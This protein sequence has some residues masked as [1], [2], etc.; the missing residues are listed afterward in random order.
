MGKA[1]F[2]VQSNLHAQGLARIL[3]DYCEQA[4]WRWGG[5]TDLQ[6]EP[7][8]TGSEFAPVKSYYYAP[9]EDR[10]LLSRSKSKF[11][12][13][14]GAVHVAGNIAYLHGP[15]HEG[16]LE[17][18]ND[19][20]LTLTGGHDNVI[21][22][23]ED[24]EIDNNYTPE[25][26]NN[27][28]HSL[29]H[30]EPDHREPN[31]SFRCPNC[32]ELF[33]SY[34]LYLQHRSDEN[35]QS[36]GDTWVDDGKFPELNMDA[37]FPPNTS[38]PL[39]FYEGAAAPQ[40]K[41]VLPAPIPF[42]YDI[43]EDNVIIGQPGQRTSDIPGKFTPGGI[44]EGT[45]EPGGKVMVRS[46]T[47]MPF[48]VR[49]ML[50]LWYYQHPELE[51][52]N[53]EMMDDE[54]KSTKLAAGHDIGGY[55]TSLVGADPTAFRASRALMQRGGNV[56]VVGGAVRDALLGKEPKDIDLMVTG[57]EPDKVH[58]ILTDLPGR[59]DLTGKDFG[60]FRYNQDG[61][62]VEIALP[63][64]E[65]SMGT[66][67]KD[68]DVQADH[69]MT[70]E[71]DLFR[72]DFT[73]NAMAVDVANGQLIDPFHGLDDLK[74]NRL[75]TLNTKS[76]SDDPLRTVR[77]LV[78][79]SKHGLIPDRETKEQMAENAH[80]VKH[81][82]QERIQ[83]ELDKLFAGKNP[84]A[85]IRQA[86]DSGLIDHIFPEVGRAVGYSQN[87]P[88]HELELGDH[89]INV[90]NRAKQAK[91]NDPD[92]ALAGLLHDIGKPDSHWTEC[93]DCGHSLHGHTDICPNCGSHNTSGH[94]YA[95]QPGIGG[96]HEDI[97]A[98]QAYE[99]MM[100]LKYPKDRAERVRDLVQH[101]MFPAFTTEKGARKFLNTVGD[102][103]DDLLHLR[104]ADQGG[105]SQYPTDP[106]LSVDQQR[107]LVEQ[108][109][110][111]GQATNK[112]QLA[113][114]GN[115]IIQAGVPQGP[116]VGQVLQYL[117]DAVLENPELNTREA[118]LGLVRGWNS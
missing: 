79:M 12:R 56:Y 112:S 109:R 66:G 9:G 15:G 106:S 98:D 1:T 85:A 48:T 107:A 6:G 71:E 35:T 86:I 59:V 7:V 16:L 69:T 42:L 87:N 61:S 20:G 8:G 96:N 44:V 4:G 72:R 83:A 103:A 11:V 26:K 10:L 116:Q 84:E 70:P 53:V 45:Y 29:F 100:A 81:L 76:L 115:D 55:I 41:D 33:P 23:I 2:E 88:H 14:A 5:L 118:L 27:D 17:W 73:A 102:H 114:N 49:H 34:R 92:F 105:K 68:F 97:G 25:W 117:T 21:K 60:V 3:K 65:R 104:W 95:L 47:N 91:P 38:E 51:V 74:A 90:M 36:G 46:M 37:T 31:G 52:K 28:E 40:P 62:E 43:Q 58:E 13:A 110:A 57:L 78:A 54:G 101:H 30:S 77:A 22:T 111:A 75:R 63:R 108:V 94:F 113:V 19:E 18:A 64:R 39:K 99:R 50:E 89:L 67:H 93:R 82:P 24:L 32:A 80:L